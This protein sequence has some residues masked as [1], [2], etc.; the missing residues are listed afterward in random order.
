MVVN[1]SVSRG[2]IRRTHFADYI[3]Y[4]ERQG[5]HTGST[6]AS[7]ARS[8]PWYDLGLRPKKERADMFWPMAQ[9]Y[10]HVVPLNKDL[11]PA[12]HNLFDLWS[13]DACKVQVLWAVLNSTVTALSKHQFGR[14]AGVEGNLKTEVIDAN[15]MLV[16]DI[17]TAS[18]E[19]AERAILAC[20]RM[21]RRR[22]GRFLHE[23][24]SLEDRRELDDATLEIL[25]IEDP[26]ERVALRDGLYRD[27]TEMQRSIRDREI[28]AQKDRRRASRRTTTTPL[29]LADEI[30]AGHESSFGLLQFPEDFVTRLNEGDLFSLPPG[31]VEVGEALMD[32]D[33]FLSA[34]TIRVGGRDGEVMDVGSIARSR[35]V[36]ALSRCHRRGQVRLPI[37]EV[38]NDAVSNFNQYL[39][40][41]QDTY[42]RL[43]QETTPNQ[44]RQRGVVDALLRKTLQWQRIVGN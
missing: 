26:D 30:W 6:V 11:L 4:A 33:G 18:P 32:A 28:I 13:R 44:R 42:W 38:C 31:T 16:P 9:Q 34:G 43:A 19:L 39:A 27:M 29:D 20:Q 3:D 25:G 36:E 40:E 22:V 10:R 5:W 15:M 24:F 23:E 14:A 37:D 12:N 7:R 2:R 35:F 21:S 8:R 1:A 41:L 17:R